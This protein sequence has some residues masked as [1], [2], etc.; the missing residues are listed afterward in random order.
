MINIFNKLSPSDYQ[1]RPYMV[2]SMQALIEMGKYITPVP[3][4]QGEITLELKT[5]FKWAD[6]S[7]EGRKYAI[8]HTYFGHLI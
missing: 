2:K 3:N 7:E 8:L 1:N 6:Q 4:P 5:I